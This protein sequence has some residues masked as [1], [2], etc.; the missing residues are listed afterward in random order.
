MYIEIQQSINSGAVFSLPRKTLEQYVAA[1]SM[2][3]AFTHFS[4]SEFPGTCETVRMALAMRVSEDANEQAKTESRIA[5]K[6]SSAALAVGLVS[7]IAALWP[8][9]VQSP[10]QVYSLQTKPV[11]VA[12]PEQ[13]LPATPKVQTKS[14]PTPSNP[15]P[16]KPV[17]AS[18]KDNK[19]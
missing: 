14:P 17:Q 13:S 8:L 7:A 9:V 12:P 15:L 6:V 1:L 10:M 18:A 5:L 11:H 3:Q 4:A 2:S 19:N 16:A